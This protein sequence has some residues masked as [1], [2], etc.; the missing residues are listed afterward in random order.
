MTSTDIGE[1]SKDAV[2]ELDTLK[3]KSRPHLLPSPPLQK[4]HHKLSQEF[5]V[6]TLLSSQNSSIF[7]Y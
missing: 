2:S 1:V 6:I 5:S 7:R 4:H 3:G